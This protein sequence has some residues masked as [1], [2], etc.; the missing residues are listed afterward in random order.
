M[1]RQGKGRLLGE[2]LVMGRNMGRGREGGRDIWQTRQ[3]QKE[4]VTG[5]TYEGKQNREHEQ[6]CRGN[7]AE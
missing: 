5:K 3:R 2:V 7:L 4:R 1:V 6:V